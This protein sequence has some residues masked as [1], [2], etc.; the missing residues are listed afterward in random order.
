M[1]ALAGLRFFAIKKG[2]QW[3]SD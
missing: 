1:G 3:Q 2:N